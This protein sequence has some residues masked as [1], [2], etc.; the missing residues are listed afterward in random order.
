MIVLIPAFEPGFR[1][2]AV[3]AGLHDDDHD[4]AVVVVDDGSGPSFTTVFDHAAAA[5]ATVLRHE[6]N[7]G[8]AA[9][10][11][12]GIDHVLATHPGDDV[13][14][15]DADGQHTARDILR[16]AD[17]L[18]E[19]A[20]DGTPALVL[21][22]R[23][24]AGR[25][26]LRSRVGNA[27]ARG[28]FRLA[29]GWSLS[30]T[31]TGLRGIPSGLLA[32]VRGQPGE[33]FAFEQH[34]LLRCRRDGVATREVPIETVY[35]DGNASSH[36]RPVVDSVRIV[37]PLLLFAASS[38]LAFVVDTVMLLLLE[39]LTGLLVPSIIAARAVS[40]SVNFAVNRRLVFPAGSTATPERRGRMPQQA[41]RYAL[42][43]VALLASNVVWLDALTRFGLPLVVAKIATEAVLF[44]T[45]YG[46][47]RSFVF[48]VQPDRLELRRAPDVRHRNSIAAPDRMEANEHPTGRNP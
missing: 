20:A 16:V 31:Q 42:L 3:I 33:R 18:R 13:V 43:A 45:S 44:V 11:R 40:A 10:L 39:A 36:F 29:A 28:I 2:E 47:Q 15:A 4:I 8:K 5:G 21:G 12:T 7:R 30:D 22:C 35:L 6:S 19:D 27:V 14:T 41:V 1:L 46:V 26:P 23:S 48:G 17:A 32:W 38:L 9:A 34:V 24:F 25:V 37:L